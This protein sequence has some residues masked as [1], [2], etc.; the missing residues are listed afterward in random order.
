MYNDQPLHAPLDPLVKQARLET[1]LNETLSLM[2]GCPDGI[3]HDR[4]VHY[5][6]AQGLL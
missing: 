5:G 1:V 6:M 2:N 3:C 4:T